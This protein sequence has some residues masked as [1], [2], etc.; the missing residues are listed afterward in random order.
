MD[1]FSLFGDWNLS[2]KDKI[3]RGSDGAGNIYG[4]V[5]NEIP[6]AAVQSLVALH[7]SCGSSKRIYSQ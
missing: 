7:I 6:L 2:L 5:H 3:M 1:G 4:S